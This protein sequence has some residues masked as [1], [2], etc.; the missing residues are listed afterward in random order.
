MNN[1][2]QNP[3]VAANAVINRLF[4]MRQLWEDA[5]TSY[6]DPSR[7]QLSLQ[8]CI[9]VSRTVTFILQSNKEHMDGFDEWYEGHRTTWNN[10]PIMRWARDARNAIEKQGD[11]IT[12]SQV[13]ATIIASYLDGPETEWLPQALFMSPEQV[14]RSVPAKFRV[15]HIIENGTL[16]IERRWVDSELPEMEVLEALSHVY[17]QFADV[18]VDFMNVNRLKVP[19]RL[20]DTRPDAMGLL[21][22]DRA[23]YLSMRDGSLSGNRYFK[24][25]LGHPGK[26]TVQKVQ[27]RY[28]PTAT[29]NKLRNAETFE[30]V[31]KEFFQH[32]RVVLQRDGHHRSFTFFLKGKQIIQMIATDHPNRASR[33]VLMRDLAKLARI[34]GADGVFMI[35]E[36]WTAAADNV[37]ESGFAVDAKDRGESLTM[38]AANS[39]GDTFVMSAQFCRRRPGSKKVKRIAPTNLERDG[40][41]FIV[42]P[43]L[44]EWGVLDMEMVAAKLKRMDDLGIGSPTIEIS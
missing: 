24:K 15:P 5:A 17:G 8:N 4:Q 9:T 18:L 6:F 1:T 36:A 21:A 23:L 12:H 44:R 7:F 13:R 43:F 22:M 2:A 25:R 26:G 29:W 11:L 39:T 14:F 16:L 41:Q 3:N 19:P 32:A 33:Y 38:H 34:E 35:A 20:A 30:D 37:P 10:D 28:G 27:K 40:I 42:F 31:A